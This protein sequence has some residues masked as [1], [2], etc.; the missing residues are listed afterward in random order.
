M[1]TV[2]GELEEPAALGWTV[3]CTLAAEELLE[4]FAAAKRFMWCSPRPTLFFFRVI[5]E[6]RGRMSAHRPPRNARNPTQ[7]RAHPS[8][9]AVPIINNTTAIN[10]QHTFLSH[11]IA[12]PPLLLLSPPTFAYLPRLFEPP[13][14]G[15]SNPAS[16]SYDVCGRSPPSNAKFVADS[17]EA[18]RTWSAYSRAAVRV[19]DP[20][21]GE[22][23]RRGSAKGAAGGEMSGG[24]DERGWRFS[25]SVS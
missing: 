19:G 12:L 25:R 11:H 15:A 2:L 24:C 6:R 4:D 3:I 7:S 8:P 22:R 20:G 9:V 5:E 10:T 14:V 21:A 1:V 13:F 23:F 18:S 17:P 16:T